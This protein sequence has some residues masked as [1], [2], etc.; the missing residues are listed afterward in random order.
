MRRPGYLGDI[1]DAWF[2]DF[3]RKSSRRTTPPTRTTRTR[4]PPTRGT[5]VE[6]QSAR[7][8]GRFREQQRAQRARQ[9]TQTR[10]QAAQARQARLTPHCTGAYAP[11]C[12]QCVARG[13]RPAGD[14]SR[15]SGQQ[16][17]VSCRIG[18]RTQYISG[19]RSISTRRAPPPGAPRTV[20]PRVG[21]PGRG[22]PGGGIPTYHE[23]AR[24]QARRPVRRGIHSEG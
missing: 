5:R 16:I 2:G 19:P 17:V 21:I 24:T 3:S 11:L 12:A 4:T 7:A 13:G 15:A 23:S 14:P 20:D 9:A 10:A 22:I 6:Q 1:S 8:Q 18:G